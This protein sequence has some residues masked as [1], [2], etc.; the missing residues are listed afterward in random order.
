MNSISAFVMIPQTTTLVRS[1]TTTSSPTTVLFGYLDDLS[2]DLYSI[3]DNPDIENS[4]KEAT[5]M[6]Q[7]F[8]DRM[9]PGDWSTYVEFNEFDG[10]DGQMGVA[11]DGKE[12]R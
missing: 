3:A 12:V 5:D 8:V 7:E 9:G 11:G 4:T 1:R 2:K 6:K 10:G